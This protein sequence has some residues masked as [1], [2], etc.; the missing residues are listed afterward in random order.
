MFKK[1]KEIYIKISDDFNEPLV[2]SKLNE[3]RGY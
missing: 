3:R 2:R 1:K